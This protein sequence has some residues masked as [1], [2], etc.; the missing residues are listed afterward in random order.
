[1]TDQRAAREPAPT[2][3]TPI[4]G[5]GARLVANMTAS[6]SM[7]TATSFREIPVDILVARRKQLNASIAPARLSFTHLI[8]YAVGQAAAVHP[9]LGAHFAEIDGRPYRVDPASRF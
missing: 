7:P 9:A 2:G 8:A 1:V 3:A 6:L 4:E 5:V